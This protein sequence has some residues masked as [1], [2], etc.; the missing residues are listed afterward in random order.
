[1]LQ[2]RPRAMLIVRRSLPLPDRSV[3]GDGVRQKRGPAGGSVRVQ[4]PDGLQQPFFFLLRPAAPLALDRTQLAN[5]L[6]EAN[7]L[8]AEFL[9][10]MKL[11]DFLLRF[12]QGN[13]IGERFGNRLT[14][15][16]TGQ[17]ELRIVAGVARFGAM[18]GGLT[19]APHN[20]GD[21]TGSQIAQ[22]EELMQ[23]LGASG[24][25]NSE[26]VRHI[27]LSVRLYTLRIMPQKKKTC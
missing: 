8:G 4:F 3:R 6:I 16:P 22:P 12:A 15:R 2:S 23:E 19:A 25:E 11:S 20:G 18:A 10:S 7:Q 13:G 21:R 17:P 24:F 26:I 1:M 14:R 5:L 9:E 27:F